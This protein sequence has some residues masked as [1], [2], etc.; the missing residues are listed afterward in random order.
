VAGPGLAEERGDLLVVGVA[1][2]LLAGVSLA[3]VDASRVDGPGMG[4]SVGE[5]QPLVP[6]GEVLGGLPCLVQ[7]PSSISAGPTVTGYGAATARPLAA[8]LR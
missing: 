1:R 3:Q 6:G 7:L 4:G 2:V 5:S 8:C